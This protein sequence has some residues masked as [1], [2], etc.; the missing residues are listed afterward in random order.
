MVEFVIAD[1]DRREFVR[2]FVTGGSGETGVGPLVGEGDRG[3]VDDGT[4]FVGDGPQDGTGVHLS[5]EGR[6]ARRAIRQMR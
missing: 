6:N 3:A 2:A 4:R 1:F 5:A